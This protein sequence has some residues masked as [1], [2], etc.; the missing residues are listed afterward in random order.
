VR[1]R[2]TIRRTAASRWT[3]KVPTIGFGQGETVHR[4]THADALREADRRIKRESSN[5]VTTETAW[6]PTDKVAPV[7]TW[8]PLTPAEM[9]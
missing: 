1:D 7:P 8:T 9:G 5:V 2:I 6:Q 3:V 4:P